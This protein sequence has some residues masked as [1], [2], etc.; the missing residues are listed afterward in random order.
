MG[1]TRTLSM[2]N[3]LSDEEKFHI[4]LASGARD[5]PKNHKGVGGLAGRSWFR[6]SATFFH[7]P[8]NH[9]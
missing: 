7:T 6:K 5:W 9:I 2:I 3:S 8:P 1:G 4:D